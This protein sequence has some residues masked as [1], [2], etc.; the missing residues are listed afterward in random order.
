MGASILSITTTG[1]DLTTNVV[2][3]VARTSPGCIETRSS[4]APS[5]PTVAE[6]AAWTRASESQSRKQLQE[7]VASHPGSQLTILALSQLANCRS[8]PGISTTVEPFTHQVLET[9]IERDYSG[10]SQGPSDLTGRDRACASALEKVNETKVNCAKDL[11]FDGDL[12]RVVSSSARE[13]RVGKCECEYRNIRSWGGEP[14]PGWQ[15]VVKGTMSCD[16]TWSRPSAV[17]VCER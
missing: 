8:K 9:G 17:E 6:Q 3:A 13:T 1:K 15:C 10:G 16:V 11:M 5:Q 12:Q 2:C 7:F 14:R 4:V